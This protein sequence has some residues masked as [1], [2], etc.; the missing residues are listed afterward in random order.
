MMTIIIPLAVFAGIIVWVF[1]PK[2]GTIKPRWVAIL[3]TTI[4]LV[5]VA[6]AALIFQLV[7]NSTGGTGVSDI[8][9][10]LFVIGLCLT[11]AAILALLGFAIARQVEI[12]KGLSFGITIM[13]ILSIVAFVSLEALSGV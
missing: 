3:V 10:T 2:A 6:V 4:P 9:N 8:S 1:R 12:T 13:V 11:G 7:Q 5:I